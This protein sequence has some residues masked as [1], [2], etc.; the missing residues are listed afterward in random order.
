MG[1]QFRAF[2]SVMV[3]LVVLVAGLFMLNDRLRQGAVSVS[4]DVHAIEVNSTVAAISDAAAGV[5]G[6]L[7]DFG[8]NN[9]FLFTF[10]A[11]AIALVLLML[12]T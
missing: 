3:A 12:R 4:A 2:A 11:A 10:L 8:T 5:V 6:V 1:K 9:T 7:G